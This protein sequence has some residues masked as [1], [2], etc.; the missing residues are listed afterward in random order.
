[1]VDR[2]PPGPMNKS[3]NAERMWLDPYGFY[4]ECA[5]RYG[6]PFTVALPTGN[7]VVT[8]EPN[9]IETIF[10]AEPDDFDVFA[11]DAQ[12]FMLGEQSIFLLNEP[13]HTTMRRF[14]APFFGTA[15]IRVHGPRI[16]EIARRIISQHADG[17]PFVMQDVTMAISLEVIIQVIF[18]ITDP[19]RIDVYSA[20]TQN[21]LASLDPALSFFPTRRNPVNG[22]WRR[23][24]Q[25]RDRLT[26]ILAAEMSARRDLAPDD[27]MIA[28]LLSATDESGQR[29]D[30]DK[31]RDQLVSLLLAG[32]ETTAISIAWA[33]SWLARSPEPLARL[34]AE[35][36]GLPSGADP[37]AIYRLSYLGAICSETMRLW[38]IGT[39]IPRRLRKPLALGGYEVPAG[40][41][42]AACPALTHA[43]EDIYPEPSAFQPERFLTRKYSPYRVPALRWW[44]TPVS[45]RRFWDLRNEDGARVGL[46]GMGHRA[47]GSRA[48]ASGP[49]QSDPHTRT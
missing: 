23:F 22:A 21:F 10:S 47:G 29:L 3:A 25:G 19:F 7:L 13:A 38:P 17:K 35:L 32:H 30:D 1:M 41:G 16:I 2:L 46:E 31:V 24:C 39:E 42:V 36:D 9:Y 6:D 18:G 43:R 28:Q 15:R 14:M 12:A 27:T 26:G 8:A 34:H 40:D 20:A 4:R 49:A 33:F 5:A 11:P 48:G 37:D 45:R 44:S